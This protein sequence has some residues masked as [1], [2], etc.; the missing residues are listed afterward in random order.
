MFVKYIT[1]SIAIMV[2]GDIAMAQSKS[3]SNL[4]VGDKIVDHIIHTINP[5]NTTNL[6]SFKGKLLIL[7]FWNTRCGACIEA[8]PKME[9]LQKIFNN[10]IQIILVND[11]SDETE[12][13][14]KPFFDKR[15]RA[16]LLDMSLPMIFGDSMLTESYFPHSSA[17]HIVWI[18]QKGIIIAI[19]LTKSVTHQNIRRVLD[20]KTPNIQQKFDEEFV[21]WNSS[22]PIFISGNGGDGTNVLYQSIIAKHVEGFA[23]DATVIADKSRDFFYITAT[24]FPLIDLYRLAYSKDRF[25][26]R[27]ARMPLSKLISHVSDTN[28][29][30]YHLVSPPTTEASLQEI[31]QEDLGRFFK[32][33]ASY[34]RIKRKCLIFTASDSSLVTGFNPAT[35]PLIEINDASFKIMNSKM[36]D[37]I[38]IME[39][40]TQYYYSPYPIIDETGIKGNVQINLEAKVFDHHELD[41]ALKK[42][43]ISFKLEERD[44]ETLILEKRKQNP[45]EEIY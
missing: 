19:T 20:E 12:A 28:K 5:V 17:P 8:M 39:Q 29:Y 31:M 1:I 10:E 13:I 34:K 27:V 4:K 11:K 37:V 42:Y 33:A 44:V 41:K 35:P 24:N 25:R 26:E 40:A 2:T 6:S 22:K 43:K 23:Y 21:Q 7:D 16:G 14:T 30:I 45:A 18:D 9:E 15:K 36:K 38:T 32:I 3:Q